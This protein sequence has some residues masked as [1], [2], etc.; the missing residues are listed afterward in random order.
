MTLLWPHMLWFALVPI[1][2]VLAS[3]S[4]ARGQGRV[5]PDGDSGQIRRGEVAAGAVRFRSP[6]RKARTPSWRF[7]SA[8]LLVTIALARPQFGDERRQNEDASAEVVIAL[9]LSRS[10]LA[11]DVLPS[12]LER[13]RAIARALADALPERRVGLLGFEGSADLLAPP[14]EDRALLSAFLSTIRPDDLAQQ[15]TNFAALADVAGA[16]F[17]PNASART[18]VVLSDG[19]AEPTPW[20]DRIAALRR[21]HVHVISV[22]LGTADGAHIPTPAG[23]PLRDRNGALVLTKSRAL[24][25]RQLSDG[26]GGDYLE[27]S[28]GSELASRARAL[29]LSQD[30]PDGQDAGT[31][32][33]Q[34]RFQWFLIAALAL[35]AWSVIVEWPAKPRLRRL[36]GRPAMAV[37]ASA[38]LTIALALPQISGA[39]PPLMDFGEPEPLNKVNAVVARLVTK[40]SLD[41][42]DY[43]DLTNA[44]IDY[45]QVHRG[46]GHPISEGVLRDGL[47]AVEMGRRLDPRLTNWGAA[48]QRLK[49]L[50]VP[51]PASK[52][53]G[54]DPADPAN[55][56][57]EGRRE[58]PVPSDNSQQQKGDGSGKNDSTRTPPADGMQTIGGRRR[59][60]YDPA[61]WRDP[62]LVQPLYLLEK[63]RENST[64]SELFRRMQQH[65]S[66][67]RRNT[68]Q[69]W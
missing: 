61:E 8:F 48:E 60:V 41:A 45:G 14:S 43:L 15:G 55:E 19:E 54:N 66:T 9:D 50:L 62:S 34:D 11:K 30:R 25:L 51:P 33:S 22:R 2:G 64:P 24:P 3:W 7:W 12:R 1:I 16:A 29:G 38:L 4:R 52:D 53:R 17:S 20:Q 26:T 46:H 47:L 65:R 23:Q 13:A 31:V 68:D 10:M 27:N 63:L 37:V 67:A 5:S 28:D 58:L 18:L 35:L 39:A 40:R 42:R 36:R 49:R 59:D 21:N 44:A 56:P 57:L 69:S 6:A 32:E